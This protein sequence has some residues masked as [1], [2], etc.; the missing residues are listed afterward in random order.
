MDHLIDPAFLTDYIPPPP[1]STK[2]KS[3]TP[4]PVRVPMARPKKTAAKKK[5]TPDPPIQPSPTK[6]KFLRD[7]SGF[8]WDEDQ[9]IV[10]A[11][12]V[13]W[14]ELLEAH[15][16]RE[17][18][19]LKD[20][21]FPV[22]DLAYSVF[23]GKAASGDLAEQE[24]FPATTDAVKLSAAAKR[25]A[26]TQLDTSD[27]DVEVD[28]ISSV[29][30]STT[31]PTKRVRDNKNSL[32]KAEMTVSTV[33]SSRSPSSQIPSSQITPHH[34]VSSLSNLVVVSHIKSPI[35]SNLPVT[36]NVIP[37]SERALDLCAERFLGKVSDDSYADFIS[38]LENEQK[39]RTFLVISRNVNDQVVLKWL[40]NQAQKQ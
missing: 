11:N 12:D 13:V 2:S 24:V 26:C 29:Q 38:V 40:E 19:K 5:K 32:I 17:F 7:Q 33:L 18:T 36:N 6:K 34:L 39:A 1:P 31:N 23:N 14:T 35:N 22:Y 37:V 10:T 28:P 25:K 9:S 20:K 4:P 30:T 15:P 27:S 21:P 3:P 8:G 16:W